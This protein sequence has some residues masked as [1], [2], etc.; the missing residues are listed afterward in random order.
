[1]VMQPG[2]RSASAKLVA[3]DATG[4][5]PRLSA[6]KH[7]ST[8]EKAIFT[9]IVASC[10]A[11][12]LV[13]VDVW[14]LGLYA[15]ALNRARKLAT[16]PDKASEWERACRVA[17]MLAR[18]LR[19]TPQSRLDKVVA[20]RMARDGSD[21]AAFKELLDLNQECERPWASAAERS[22]GFRVGSGDALE[23]DDEQAG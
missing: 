13:A 14:L 1:M 4:R 22:R 6:P 21:A 5:R 7:L 15:Q 2:R 19:L 18:S 12:Q 11:R 16:K 9:G 3:L 10:D 23:D 20:G 8:E 17:T